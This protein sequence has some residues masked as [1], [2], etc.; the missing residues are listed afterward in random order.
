MAQFSMT[1]EEREAFLADVHIGVLSI[2]EQNQGPLTVPVWYA[3][4]PGGEIHICTGQ[5]TRKSKLL[6]SVE[7]V[8]L[9][10][11]TETPPYRYVSVEGPVVSI[12]PADIE[13]D[14][15]PMAQRYLGEAGGNQWVEGFLERV[16]QDSSATENLIRIRP[17]R[18]LT[19]D[20][21]K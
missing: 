17:E 19:V 13:G 8:S 3:Y 18:W 16:K 20:Y 4:T 6:A 7:R 14:L 2:P 10:A 5:G 21:S 15:R 12:E 9:C 1:R 11:Q